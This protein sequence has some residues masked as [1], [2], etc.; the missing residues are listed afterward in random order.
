[1]TD[2]DNP[3]AAPDYVPG[4]DELDPAAQA[5][6]GEDLLEPDPVDDE[7]Q[8]QRLLVALGQ[9]PTV[10]V[11]MALDVRETIVLHELALKGLAGQQSGHLRRAGEGDK[12][13]AVALALRLGVGPETGEC[14]QSLTEERLAELGKAERDAR[15]VDDLAHAGW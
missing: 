2:L 11:A 5:D 4:A 10:D 15:L 8:I 9:V 6:D 14:K 12:A 3:D 1:M 13:D 7:A